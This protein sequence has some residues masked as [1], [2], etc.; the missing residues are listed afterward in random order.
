MSAPGHQIDIGELA[1]EMERDPLS[2]ALFENAQLK[3]IA[4]QQAAQIQLLTE[5]VAE[6]EQQKAPGAEGPKGG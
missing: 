6:L 2:K 3:V 4:R 1:A 5:R